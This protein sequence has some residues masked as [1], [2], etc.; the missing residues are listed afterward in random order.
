MPWGSVLCSI[1]VHVLDYSAA[2]TG[3]TKRPQPK[4]GTSTAFHHQ[5]MTVEISSIENAMQTATDGV[6]NQNMYGHT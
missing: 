2:W 6:L 4:E 5:Q 1:T 3:E